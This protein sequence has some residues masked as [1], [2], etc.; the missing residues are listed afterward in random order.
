M[1]GPV[2]EKETSESVK[3]MKNIPIRPPLS[4]MR[5]E[6]LAQELGRVISK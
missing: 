4:A 5:S 6:R 1:I 3:A 2:Q